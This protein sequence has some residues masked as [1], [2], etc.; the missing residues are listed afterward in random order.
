[1]E[2]N[3]KVYVHIAPNGKR[4]Y[5]ITKQEVK[6][7][8]NSGK[9]YR[10]NKYFTNAINKYGWNNFEHIILFDNLTKAEA[11]LMEKFY[12]ALYDTI[13]PNK[14]YNLSLGGET[15][16]VHT[17]ESK[18]KISEAKKGKSVH[19]EE[20][21]KKI[22]EAN[23]GKNNPFYG[24]HHTEEVRKKMSENH[25]DYK[26]KNHPNAIKIYC[27]ELDMYFDT[28]KEA[29]EYVGCCGETISSVLKG[30]CKTAKGYHWLYAKEVNEENINRV[31]SEEYNINGHGKKIYCV[32]LDMYFDSITEA[33]E[34]VGCNRNNISAI[35]NGRQK[36]AKGYHWLYA[37]DV[38]QEN[39]NKVMSEEK[40]ANNKGKNNIMAK[41]IYC[42]ELDMYF[43]TI[44]EASKYI[45]CSIS[46]ISMVL[47][48]RSKTA[49]GMHW[50]YAEDVEK[51]DIENNK[52]S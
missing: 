16:T 17:E 42:V 20:S 6:R 10:K 40:Y 44:T 41:Q 26:G 23:K 4:Y 47:R 2:M 13:N 1:M 24:K 19:T 15:G 12:I 3:Y 8:W 32:E 45:G 38:S 49:K 43:D 34:Y 28:V 30:E 48:G 39:I 31:M 25:A 27:V 35:L 33:C 46:S 18:K 5:G 37:E 29:G 51:L 9:G 36:T 21:K 7:R 14:G 52:V 11:E 22:S 50:L